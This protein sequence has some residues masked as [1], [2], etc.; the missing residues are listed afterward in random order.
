MLECTSVGK[1]NGKEMLC[2]ISIQT[3]IRE[4]DEMS[5]LRGVMYSTTT[6]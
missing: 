3:V 2:I 1:V 6:K 4:R 5:E